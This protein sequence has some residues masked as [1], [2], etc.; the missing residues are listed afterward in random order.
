MLS[1]NYEPSLFILIIFRQVLTQLTR[2]ALDSTL[3]SRQTLN[4]DPLSAS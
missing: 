1:L 2:L 3:Y 4:L